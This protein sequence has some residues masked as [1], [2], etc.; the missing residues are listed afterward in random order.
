MTARENSEKFIR[1]YANHLALTTRKRGRVIAL[2]WR[3][4]K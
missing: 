1:M 3:Y 2:F 4:G